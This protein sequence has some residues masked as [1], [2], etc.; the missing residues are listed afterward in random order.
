MASVAASVA[1][2]N[3]FLLR[4]KPPVVHL[5]QRIKYSCIAASAQHLACG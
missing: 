3:A 2:G 4:E 1:A 5:G